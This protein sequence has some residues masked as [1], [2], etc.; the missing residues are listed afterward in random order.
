MAQGKEKFIFISYAL[1]ILDREIFINS[2]V[3]TN[4]VKEPINS[5]SIVWVKEPLTS[6]DPVA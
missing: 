2:I 6:I 5:Y 3:R 1:G 4:K